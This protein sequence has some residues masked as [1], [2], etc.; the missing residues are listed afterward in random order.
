MSYHRYSS[1]ARW[2]RRTL[3]PSDLL[4]RERGPP[5][6]LHREPKQ[7]LGTTPAIRQTRN[8]ESKVRARGKSE[9]CVQR[10][11]GRGIRSSQSFECREPTERSI[12][13]IITSRTDHFL[14]W[15]KG[16][17]GRV[18]LAF[19]EFFSTA[20]EGTRLTRSGPQDKSKLVYGHCHVACRPFYF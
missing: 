18:T 14:R 11:T 3:L 7:S 10:V 9:L 20:Q 19:C 15:G 2:L 16:C 1:W 8:E 13:V 4:Q 17:P 5:A 12:T 6:C